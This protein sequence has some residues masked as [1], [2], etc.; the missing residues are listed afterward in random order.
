MRWERRIYRNA[1]QYANRQEGQGGSLEGSC[2]WN[3]GWSCMS[4][5]IGLDSGCRIYISVDSGRC[6]KLRINRY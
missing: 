3:V 2:V 4:Y 5:I 6:W 1:E